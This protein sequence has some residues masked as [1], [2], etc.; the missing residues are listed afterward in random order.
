MTK[1]QRLSMRIAKLQAEFE[2]EKT[3]YRKH[4]DNA[5][6]KDATVYVVREAFVKR[7]YRRATVAVRVKH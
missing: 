3:K 2:D 4:P 6:P 7:H 5:Q 1:L